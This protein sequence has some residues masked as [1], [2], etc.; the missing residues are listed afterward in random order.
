MP[1][2]EYIGLDGAGKSTKGIVDADSPKSARGRLRKQGVF[3]TEVWEKK[4]GATRGRGINVEIDFGKYF[5]RVSVQDLATLT[6]QLSTLVGAGIPMVEALNALVDQTENPKLK[7]VL[8]EVRQK[9]NGGTSLARAM[10]AH[11]EIFGDLFVNMVDAGEQSGALDLV[12]TRLT[13]YTESQVAL[14]G[15]LVT[16]I[17]YPILMMLV[18][19]ALVL[20][21]FT[22]VIPRIKRIFD[23]FGEGLPF[24]TTVLFTISNFVTGYWWL[25][26]IML[27]GGVWGLR[28]FV[29]TP[30]G[31]SW[32]D[33][34]MLR[35]P[36]FGKINRLVAVS[37]FCRTLA[38]LLVSGVPILT[39]L[40]IVRTVVGNE[41]IATAIDAAGRNIA[42]GQ[43]IAVPLKASG[44]FPPIVTHMI[45]I[46]EKTGEL[47][48]MLGKVADAYDSQV[49]NTVN[50]LTSLLTPILTL[51]MGGVVAVIALG[52]LLPMLNLS[53]VV[54]R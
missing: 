12:L 35:L 19:S 26:I 31:H 36:V 52:I 27:V 11:P 54:Q 41:V 42:E 25:C 29:K 39:A 40:S 45:T 32:W 33:R 8:V 53:S 13:E 30:R 49:E 37:R 48:G 3:P 22:F 28:R 2:Y 43:S 10:R 47:E 15:K 18:S 1:V 7:S 16:A 46:G 23:S 5:Q 20:G 50:T 51:F 34:T 24:I 4:E 21:L 17:T 9:V 14:R 44:Q 38:T 6:S